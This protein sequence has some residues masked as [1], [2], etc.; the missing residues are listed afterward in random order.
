MSAIIF[1]CTIFPYIFSTVCAQFQNKVRDGDEMEGEPAAVTELLH[2]SS[3]LPASIGRCCLSKSLWRILNFQNLSCPSSTVCDLR[4]FPLIWGYLG[5]ETEKWMYNV[6]KYLCGMPD[7]TN[8]TKRHVVCVSRQKW[9]NQT[10]WDE[11]HELMSRIMALY[12]EEGW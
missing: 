12:M 3:R 9:P 2:V 1:Y 4:N 6:Q 7:M 11:K 10:L 5:K 8:K